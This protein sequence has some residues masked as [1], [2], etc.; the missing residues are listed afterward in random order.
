[1]GT[2]AC[3]E[4]ERFN[5]SAWVVLRQI[6]EISCDFQ[7]NGAPPKVVTN[8]H[9]DFTASALPLG[10]CPCVLAKSAS[11]HTFK[12]NT[13]SWFIATPLFDGSCW[14]MDDAFD[15]SCVIPL[16]MQCVEQ[17]DLPQI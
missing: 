9:C 13:P 14:A 11:T 8:P 2:I 15:G 4:L 16:D 17:L 1:M 6:L 7:T 10:S 12:S 3:M 5:H